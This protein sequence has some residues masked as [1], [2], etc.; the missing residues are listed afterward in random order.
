[1]FNAKLLNIAIPVYKRPDKLRE[2]LSTILLDQSN[3]VSVSIY[4]DSESDYLDNEAV[5]D[6]FR[7][8]LDITYHKNKINLGIDRN[9]ALCFFDSRARYTLVIGEDDLFLTDGISNIINFLKEKSPRFL[10]LKYNYFNGSKDI[11]WS[12]DITNEQATGKFLESY[13]DK[14]GFIG[15]FVIEN[16]FFNMQLFRDDRTYFNH[17]GC[18]LVGLDKVPVVYST[19]CCVVRNRVGNLDAFSWKDE[20]LN[21]FT[22]FDKV[23]A[24]V[25]R[26]RLENINIPSLR[27]IARKKFDPFT[28]KRLIRLKSENVVTNKDIIGLGVER[29]V[30]PHRFIILLIPRFVCV[31][32]L[33]LHSRK[34]WS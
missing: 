22:G 5:V 33:R 24:L 8:K 2:L 11:V 20:A 26:L 32:L 14:L 18:L 25:E 23:L 28:F 17:V 3:D 6:L 12:S 27:K 30:G 21:V 29:S 19:S 13:I 9:I 15:S 1:M 34:I 10:F 16:A 4:D 7:E 31:F